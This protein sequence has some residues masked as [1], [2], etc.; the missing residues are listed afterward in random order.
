M[1]SAAGLQL[2]SSEL[3][4]PLPESRDLWLAPS[5]MEWKDM[6]LR[7]QARHAHLKRSPSVLELMADPGKT[8]VLPDMLDHEV[9]QL[10]HIY[11]VSSLVREFKQAQSIFSMKESTLTRETVMVDESQEKRLDQILS[12]VRIGHESSTSRHAVVWSMLR[13]LTAMHLHASFD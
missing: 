9:A 7:L 10:A 5:A 13:E 3:C 11:G 2:S 4:L 1:S 12:I 8:R 6:Y